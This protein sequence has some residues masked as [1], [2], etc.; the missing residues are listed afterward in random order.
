MKFILAGSKDRY[1]K[2]KVGGTVAMAF[3]TVP[4]VFLVLEINLHA[5]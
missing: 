2:C 5:C 1:V 4:F 3:S